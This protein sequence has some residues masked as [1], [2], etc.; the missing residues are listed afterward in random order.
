MQPPGQGQLLQSLSWPPVDE[1]IDQPWAPCRP[2]L[3]TRGSC[4]LPNE[5]AQTLVTKVA[6]GWD[7]VALG[8]PGG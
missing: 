3:T 1:G 4:P 6:K 8:N 2:S 5:R 7:W